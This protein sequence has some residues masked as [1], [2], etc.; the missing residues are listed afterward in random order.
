M[1][2]PLEI[3]WPMIPAFQ[4]AKNLEVTFDFRGRLKKVPSPK[5]VHVLIPEICK[6][7]FY[8]K[9]FASAIMLNILRQG[10]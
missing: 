1:T 10:E 5:Y 9:D 2:L 7:Y 8:G 6:C 3:L 4:K